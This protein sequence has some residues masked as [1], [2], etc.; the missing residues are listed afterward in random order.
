MDIKLVE[1]F[2]SFAQIPDNGTILATTPKRYRNFKNLFWRMD[3]L[4]TFIE[5]KENVGITKC[6]FVWS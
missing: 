5:I 6:Y 3:S 4:E 2:M 1:Y